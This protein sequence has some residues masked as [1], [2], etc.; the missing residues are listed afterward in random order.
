MP[1]LRT[2][3]APALRDA[4]VLAGGKLFQRAKSSCPLAA[5]SAWSFLAEIRPFGESW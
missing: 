3:G 4:E 5:R 2:L 1:I